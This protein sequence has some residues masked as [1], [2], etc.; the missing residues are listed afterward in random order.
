MS[1][2]FRCGVKIVNSIELPQYVEFKCTRW[3]L[4]GSLDK[5]GREYGLQLKLLKSEITKYNYTEM[6]H[7]GDH[8]L[9][10]M[11]YV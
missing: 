3:H 9:I 8:L 2:S 11:F 6:R 10:E 7:F 5:I 1:L 4:S